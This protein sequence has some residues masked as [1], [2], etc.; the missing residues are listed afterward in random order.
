MIR[1]PMARYRD[2]MVETLKELVS[3]PSLKDEPRPNMP[4]GK[5]VFRALIY[6]L[7]TAAHM[8]LENENLFG[9]MGYAS[10]GEGDETLA[11]LVHLDVVPPG[12]EWTYEP[13]NPVVVDGKMYGRG[14]IDD[15]GAAV[16]ALYALHMLR[17]NCVTLDKKV[18]V[19]FGC[20][21]ESGWEDMDFYK[22][23]YPEPQMA[24]VPDGC[25]PVINREKGVLHVTVTAPYEGAIKSL[26]SGSRPNIVP[27]KAECVIDASAEKL[28]KAVQAFSSSHAVNIAITETE[29]GVHLNAKGR[30]AHGAHPEQ[31][32]NALAHLLRFLAETGE[33]GFAKTF[34]KLIGTGW[35]GR[36][37]GIDCGDEKMGFLTVNLGAAELKDGMF[38]AKVDIR[39]PVNADMEAIFEKVRAAFGERGMQVEKLHVMPS[40]Y[41]DE[42]SELVSTLKE[43]YNECTGEPGEAILCCGATYARAFKNSVAFGPVP[44][45][46]ESGEH[47]PDEYIEIDRLVTLAEVLATA[48]IELAASE[49]QQT[50]IF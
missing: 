28:R 10:Y 43:V 24:I 35:S 38:S 11:I 19:I 33:G 42:E 30:A 17:E 9:H 37:L 18:M 49:T 23:N 39:T 47:G 14:T 22:A 3:I 2:E 26:A 13:F 6:M 32:I 40:H 7:D 1:Y 15:K 21:E 44:E 34:T 36:E 45:G 31:G 12:D 46:L 8:D 29:D 41:V 16:A 5:E 20:D 25:F 27:N 50:D 48:I 4:Y